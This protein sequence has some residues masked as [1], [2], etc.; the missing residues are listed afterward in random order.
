MSEQDPRNDPAPWLDRWNLT[1][2]GERIVTHSSVLVP[3][4][5]ANGPSCSS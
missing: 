2:T 5:R 1:V 3:A 4:L